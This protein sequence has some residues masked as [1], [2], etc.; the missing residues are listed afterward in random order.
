MLYP[1]F[2]S[3]TISG[4]RGNERELCMNPWTGEFRTNGDVNCI[5]MWVNNEQNIGDNP[6]TAIKFKQNWDDNLVAIQLIF[7]ES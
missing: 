3:G 5:N 4:G 2:V 1:A 6:L 7:A